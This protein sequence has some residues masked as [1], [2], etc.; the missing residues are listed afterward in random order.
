MG[1]LQS[2]RMFNNFNGCY[3]IVHG[4][5]HNNLNL[6]TALWERVGSQ[7]IAALNTLRDIYSSENVWVSYR[8]IVSQ[9]AVPLVPWLGT[10]LRRFLSLSN[11]STS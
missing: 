3:A 11:E 2:C 10:F 4:L 6:S 9:T 1:G 8:S 5:I 7:Y